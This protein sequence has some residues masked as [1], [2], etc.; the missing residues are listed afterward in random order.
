MNMGLIVVALLLVVAVIGLRR[1]WIIARENAGARAPEEKRRAWQAISP[2]G[3]V[4]LGSH[5]TYAEALTMAAKLGTV[6]YS[7]LQHGL[8]FYNTDL[9]AN[10]GNN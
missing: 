6:S 8:I 2:H 5:M 7:D 9:G 3:T 1:I 10:R 4:V